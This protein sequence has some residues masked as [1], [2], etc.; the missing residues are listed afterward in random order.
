MYLVEPYQLRTD[1]FEGPLEVLLVLIE[2][3][4]LLINDIALAEVTDDFLK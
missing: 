2:K 1:V 4:K 3:R